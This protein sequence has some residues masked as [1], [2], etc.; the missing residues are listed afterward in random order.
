[1]QFGGACTLA[2]SPGTRT[3]WIGNTTISNLE[4]TPRTV[5]YAQRLWAMPIAGVNE[6]CAMY[7][8]TNPSSA[9]QQN[10][11]IYLE[12]P[13][14]QQD[15]WGAGLKCIHQ[16]G[17]DAVYVAA[18]ASGGRCFEAARFSY[19]GGANFISTYQTDRLTGTIDNP[20]YEA[21]FCSTAGP[22]APDI[23][24]NV[25]PGYGVFYANNASGRAF[26]AR[27]F[28]DGNVADGN[29]MI[30]VQE[31]D[32]RARFQ[33]MNDGAVRTD[34]LAASAATQTRNSPIMR[35]SGS[36]WDGAAT[37]NRGGY[38]QFAFDV[39]GTP[40]GG[41]G[42]RFYVGNEG[43]ESLAFIVRSTG[44]DFNATGSI[45]NCTSIGNYT[46]PFDIT[47]N[48]ATI[49]QLT[50]TIADGETGLLLRRNVGG[51]YSLQRVSMG[52]VD[53]GGTGYRLLR[54]AN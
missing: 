1:M 43:A 29:P 15:T 45:T 51:T 18:V 22:G 5:R 4:A 49:A 3:M 39:P 31:S 24:G 47:T 53:S 50:S 2:T 44:L 20:A 48:G 19:G 12:V 40:G 21:L 38:F 13:S 36:Y 16:G 11:G 33:V 25:L 32:F 54:V 17:G 10:H 41:H 42:F 6:S 46:A 34:A 27:K 35:C 23:R 26:V 37:Q 28:G 8:R 7:I 14:A 30:V 9:E 52:A